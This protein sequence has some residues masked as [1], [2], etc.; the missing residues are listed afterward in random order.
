MSELDDIKKQ[1]WEL[2]KKYEDSQKEI[3]ELKEK[4]NELQEDVDD[5]DAVALAVPDDV[6]YP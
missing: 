2:E 5:L 6:V 4:L 1:L 3:T